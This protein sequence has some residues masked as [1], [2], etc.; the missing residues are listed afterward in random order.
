MTL[1][2]I[3]D[4]VWLRLEPKGSDES[5][6]TREEVISSARHYYST[7]VWQNAKS[8]KNS[9]G[10]YDVPSYLLAE[11]EK[12]VVNN[13]LDVSDLQALKSLP[14]EGWLLNIGGLACECDY[15]KSTVNRTSLLCDDE[16]F[17]GTRSYYIVG[18]KIRFPRG[19]HKKKLTILYANNGSDVDPL[20]YIDESISGLLMDKLADAYNVQRIAKEDV[21]NNSSSNS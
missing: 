16:V 15:I 6:T 10:Y 11:V 7:L 17:E 5:A 19:A 1:Q 20:I 12:D 9:E 8:E 18:N 2:E 21:T 13:E 14:N 4:L 3:A